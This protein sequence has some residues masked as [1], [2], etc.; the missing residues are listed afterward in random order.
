M[1]RFL[2]SF[3]FCLAVL[4]FARAALAGQTVIKMEVEGTRRIEVDAVLSKLQTHVGDVFDPAVLDRD[5]RSIYAMGYFYDV[6]VE[7]R[8]VD[9]G[10]ELV[11]LVEE[12]PAVKEFIFVGN[13][14]IDDDKI[15]E[16]T[17]LKPN[18]ILSDSTIKESIFKIR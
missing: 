12:K 14:K 16:E 6:R 10:I 4:G 8:D 17:D 5:I 7:K 9:A 2:F 13:S 15:K 1:R 18:T 3:V 11:Y